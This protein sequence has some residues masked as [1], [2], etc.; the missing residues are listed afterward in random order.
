MPFVT[1]YA[2]R[3]HELDLARRFMKAYEGELLAPW[4]LVQ[5]AD[6]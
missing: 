2:A 4:D 3:Y 1:Q 6:A 5:Q